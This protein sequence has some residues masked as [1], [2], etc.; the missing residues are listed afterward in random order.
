[1]Y[2][3]YQ[4]GEK[5]P[6]EAVPAAKDAETLV[7]SYGATKMTILSVSEIVDDETTDK[8]ELRYQGPLY[9][10]IDCKGDLKQAAESTIDLICSLGDYGLQPQCLKIYASG[11]KGFH[12]VVPAKVFSSGRPS[13]DLPKIYAAMALQMY[14]HGLDFQVYC[15]GR[16]N[17]WRLSNL[18]REDGNYRVR[19]DFGELDSVAKADSSDTAFKLY[20]E[21]VKSPRPDEEIPEQAIVKASGLSTLFTTSKKK[22]ADRILERQA[23]GVKP[24]DEEEVQTLAEDPPACVDM[25]TQYKVKTQINFNDAALQFAVWAARSKAGQ[26]VWKPRLNR[27]ADAG[28]S[29]KYD[30][31]RKRADH[32]ESLVRYAKYN[33][34]L[35]FSCHAM[36]RVVGMSPCDG[37]PISSQSFKD[38]AHEE[39]LELSIEARE[40]GYY[41]VGADK[42][43]KISTFTLEPLNQTVERAQSD[44]HG[45]IRR[46]STQ[47][48]IRRNGA[49][50]ATISFEESGWAS[51]AAFIRQIEGV[52]N[53]SFLGSDADVQRIKHIVYH[54]GNEMGEIV[55]VF[56]VGVH[57]QEDRDGFVYVEPG[58]SVT[59][60]R[61]KGLYEVAGKIPAPAKIW[62]TNIPQSAEEKEK[63]G[64]AL[65]ALMRVNSKQAV[66]QILGWFSACHL[67]THFMRR[68]TQFPILSLWGSAG[69]GKTMSATLFAWLNGVDYTL[70]DS[71]LNV[72]S[73]TQWVMIAYCS[74]STTVPRLLDEYN[75]SKMRGRKYD[76]AGEVIKAAWNGQCLGRGTL[77][78]SR[79]NGRTG[80]EVAEIP[81]SGPLVI[82]SEQ[83]P[84]TPAVQQ[85]T[86][87][88]L[89]TR[90]GRKGCEGHFERASELREELRCIAKAMTM[91][92]IETPI[93]WI[94]ERMEAYKDWVPREIDERPRYSYKVLL[95]GLDYLE[96]SVRSMGVED[97]GYIEE[98]RQE[99]KDYL[100]RESSDIQK[101]KHWTE[102]DSVLEDIGTM[103]ALSSDGTDRW[104]QY[105]RHIYLDTA[106]RRLYL[107]LP[108]V[109]ATYLRYK[110]GRDDIPL[111]RLNQLSTLLKQ[112]IYFVSDKCMVERMN[113][114]R[115]MWE[116]DLDRM[117]E[118]GHTV[119]MF[120]G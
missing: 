43:R 73:V 108:V 69:S 38:Q 33:Q 76:E 7:R 42:D 78:R 90:D 96:K 6:W 16:G 113:A 79:A 13:K 32:L 64:Q 118:K 4:K 117:E 28:S 51:K 14:V 22:V 68:Y 29:S 36:R 56:S 8:Q 95:V 102:V 85:R 57:K 111:Y 46:V 74:S 31:H 45:A 100:E 62:T 83:A 5:S 53:L 3:Y 106:N 23:S 94:E 37:C 49:S 72:S 75:R 115:P 48:E 60:N 114:S 50:L 61:V 18:Q 2:Y 101:V 82:M 19:V 40:D 112:E 97:G 107:D 119:T 77:S 24:L 10:D 99:L 54:E 47:V 1:M 52:Q 109:H 66:A 80:A 89:M 9:F 12:V 98:L 63:V 105:G 88:I 93:S 92:S 116:L 27:M 84:D 30:N 20:R 39:G 41:L 55:R 91:I 67:K 35:K 25:L 17:S 86:V 58:H 21:L 26:E 81:I 70:N 120:Q 65:Q 110:G 104:I 87:Q 34:G 59:T 103:V 71:P 15:G 44:H 11:G